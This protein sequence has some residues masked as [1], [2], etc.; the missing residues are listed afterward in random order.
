MRVPIDPC[1]PGRGSGRLTA[2]LSIPAIRS[3]RTP[4]PARAA[5]SDEL[6]GVLSDKERAT[7]RTFLQKFAQRNINLWGGKMPSVS[8]RLTG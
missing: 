5:A 3:R 7:L 1:V 4:T 2:Y 8:G 6:F